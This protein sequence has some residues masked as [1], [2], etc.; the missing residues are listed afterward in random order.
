MRNGTV[1]EEKDDFKY[2]S[3][4]VDESQ[5]D[6]SV[7]KGLAWKALN[8]MNRIWKP[9]RNPALQQKFFVA[10]VNPAKSQTFGWRF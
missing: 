1:L 2:L 3:S 8:D 5:E 6:I 9:N 10:T 7:R 4:R